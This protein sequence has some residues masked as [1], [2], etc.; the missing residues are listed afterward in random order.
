[1]EPLLGQP[2]MEV[3]STLYLEAYLYFFEMLLVLCQVHTYTAMYVCMKVYVF[4]C[5]N[6][7]VPVHLMLTM[8]VYC[9][10]NN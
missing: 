6:A 5:I 10:W 8:C 9:S 7:C 1:M 4:M 2:T 3:P